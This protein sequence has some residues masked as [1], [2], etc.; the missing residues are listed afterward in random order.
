MTDPAK[1]NSENSTNTKRRF[2]PKTPVSLNPPDFNTNFTKAQLRQYDG[3]LNPEQKRYISIK[4][5]IFDVSGNEAAYGEGTK[6]SVFCGYDCSRAL[7]FSSLDLKDVQNENLEDFTEKQWKT[8][9][10]WYL[11]FQQRYN[12]V[13]V[14]ENE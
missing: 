10:D 3:H 9:N 14:L 5:H 7:G 11:F 6:Y 13:G 1:S 2:A 8:L 12:I 4:H